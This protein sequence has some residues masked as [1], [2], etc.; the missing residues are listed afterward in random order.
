MKPKQ[1]F[2]IHMIL[3]YLCV[4][5]VIVVG[6]ISII[7]TGGGGDD[8]GGGDPCVGPVPCLTQ[9]WGGTFYEFQDP[10]GSPIIITSYGNVYAGA[11]FNEDGDLIGLG[12]DVIDCYNGDISEG[13]IDNN[14]PDGNIDDW[15][16][17]VSGNLNICNTTLRISGLVIEGTPQPEIVATYVGVF[18]GVATSLKTNEDQ[19]DRKIL[20]EILFDILDKMSREQ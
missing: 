5:C 16:T 8:G 11:G 12:G 13:A 4:S 2:R 10:N 1:A 3:R 15:F 18:V 20:P 17:S 14:P 9:D 19:T 6:F 7:G